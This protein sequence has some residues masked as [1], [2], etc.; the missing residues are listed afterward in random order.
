MRLVAVAQRIGIEH[1]GPNAADVDAKS[2]F[3]SEAMAAIKKEK[4]LSALVPTALGGMGCGMHELAA[5]CEALGEHCSAASMIFAMHQ[6]QVACLVRHAQGS[7]YFRGYLRELADQQLLIASVTSEVG[8][9]GDMR[10]S[11]SSVQIDGAKLVLNKDATT[12]SYGEHADDLLVT[13]R[14]AADAPASGL[15]NYQRR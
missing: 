8:I 10:S 14:R 9:G 5:I 3:P 15:P 4:L 12:I 6:I 1:A 2:R 13:T 7:E 11:I